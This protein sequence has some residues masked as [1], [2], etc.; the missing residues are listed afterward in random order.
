MSNGKKKKQ[1]FKN[2][3]LSLV[4]VTIETHLAFYLLFQ[5]RIDLTVQTLSLLSSWATS[6]TECLM[7]FQKTPKIFQDTI[8]I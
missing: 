6:S 4:Y 7:W 2:E 3:K 1:T 5:T 8:V